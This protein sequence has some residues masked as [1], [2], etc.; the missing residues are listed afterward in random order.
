[1]CPSYPTDPRRQG[2][3]AKD[4]DDAP[5]HVK[6][7]LLSWSWAIS[8]SM[9][10][11]LGVARAR[12]DV[13]NSAFF[14]DGARLGRTSVAEEVE[15]AVAPH[16]RCEYTKF[17]SAGAVHPPLRML[18]PRP[19]RWRGRQAHLNDA[20]RAPCCWVTWQLLSS[21]QRALHKRCC[22]RCT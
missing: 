9:T 8:S 2:A 3:S 13:S 22:N 21:W 7:L 15:R 17:S 20:P 14:L 6:R 5:Q 1:M 10:G 19:L 16:Y 12:R 18:M 4:I 11:A